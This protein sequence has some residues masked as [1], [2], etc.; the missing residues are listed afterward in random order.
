MKTLFV[1][2]DTCFNSSQ[3][4][5]GGCTS[6]K[7][8]SADTTLEIVQLQ[9]CYKVISFEFLSSAQFPCRQFHLPRTVSTTIACR[10]TFVKEATAIYT[11]SSRS[12]DQSRGRQ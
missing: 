1:S 9:P 12:R 10:I 6:H 11:Q 5:F 8:S 4:I 2:K 3:K 7:V